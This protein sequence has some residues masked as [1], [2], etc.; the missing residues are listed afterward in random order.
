MV[1]VGIDVHRKFSQVCA[2]DGRGE[3]LL[4]RRVVNEPEA[5][6]WM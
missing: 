4:S 2:L 6:A 3:V 1:Y 5:P